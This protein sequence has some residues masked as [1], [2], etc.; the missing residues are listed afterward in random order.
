MVSHEFRTPL[1]IINTSVHHE[2]Q[3]LDASL[4]RSLE[5]YTNIKEAARRMSDLMDEYLSLDR[6]EGTTQTLNLVSCEI[7]EVVAGVV[8][9]WP[10]HLIELTATAVPPTLQCDWKLLQVAL[11]NLISNG[12]RQSPPD[13]PLRLWIHGQPGGGV[14]IEIKDTGCGI[15]NDEIGRIFESIFAVAVRWASPAPGW[16]SIWW[17]A[18]R[19]CMAVGL[20]CRRRP[21]MA[22]DL[23]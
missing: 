4:G 8:A 17:S 12:L 10:A 9:E 13:E 21:T 3:S 19:R 2:A 1:A 14:S 23:L 20:R 11:R 15:T 16:D 18:L 22:A 6:I 5:R 7:R